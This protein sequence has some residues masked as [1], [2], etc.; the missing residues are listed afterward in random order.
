MLQVTFNLCIL[1][2]FLLGSVSLPVSAQ[3]YHWQLKQNTQDSS[4]PVLQ[5]TDYTIYLPQISQS[6]T[7]DDQVFEVRPGALRTKSFDGGVVTLVAAAGSASA[8]VIFQYTPE[9]SPLPEALKTFSI[10]ASTTWDFPLAAQVRYSNTVVEARLGIF[11]Y[12]TE[13]A[14]WVEIPSQV[15][16]DTVV[17]LI[18]Q[19]GRYALVQDAP[20]DE[21]YVCL[22]S[23]AEMTASAAQTA[24]RAIR[25]QIDPAGSALVQV[26]ITGDVERAQI[27]GG[28]PGQLAVPLAHTPAYGVDVWTAIFTGIPNNRVIH[29]T[30]TAEG[31]DGSNAT[32]EGALRGWN[33]HDPGVD[34]IHN[35][36]DGWVPVAGETAPGTRQR[37][38][39]PHSDVLTA[40]G[41][42]FH[43]MPLLSLPG[44]GDSDIKLTLTY[45]AQGQADGPVG[46]GWFFSYGMN[47][48]FVDTPLLRGAEIR[49]PDG[50]L[51]RFANVGGSIFEPVDPGIN[52]RLEST[53]AGYRLTRAKTL[54]SY[55]F[56]AEGRLTGVQD[57][58]QNPVR[59][60]YE[61]GRLVR[62]ENNGLRSSTLA[63]NEAGQ[64]VSITASSRQVLLAYE[65][66]RL[67]S[68]TDAS[69][70]VWQFAY[71]TRET[72][73]VLGADGQEITLVDQL[74]T[75]WTDPNGAVQGRQEYDELGRV[76]EQTTAASGQRTFAYD[77]VNRE[78]VVTDAYD[79]T[80]RYRFDE[81]WRLVEQIAPDGSRETFGYDEDFNRTRYE[82]AAG[83]V[84]QWGYD[85]AG[86]LLREEGPLGWLRS[87][88]YNTLG[89]PVRAAENLD[90]STTRES[91]FTYDAAGNLR[92]ITN[93]LG[94]VADYRYDER[95][96]LTRAQD[97]AGR[98]IYY[99]YNNRGDLTSRSNGIESTLFRRDDAGRLE[100]LTLPEGQVYTYAYDSLDRLTAVGGPLSFS[101]TY[102]YDPS[103]NLI[104]ETAP[105]GAV[106][107]YEVDS[108]G[109]LTAEID[110]LGSR[111]TY[112]YGAMGE[113]ARVIDAEGRE[114]EF[115]YDV[116]QRMV[117]VSEP[118]G[119]VTRYTYDA[120]GNRVS[121]TDAEGRVLHTEF[122]AL[123]RP[124][125]VTEN[126]R[127]G[128]P[129]SAD[130][131]L[132]TT[133]IYDLG[134]RALQTTDPEGNPT[135]YTYDLLDRLTVLTNAEGGLWSF[136]YDPAGSLTS[137]T[138]PRGAVTGYD[139]DISNRLIR[140]TD[141]Y[142]NVTRYEYN[143][144]GWQTAV[145]DPLGVVT[146]YDYDDLGRAVAETRS[147]VPG[148]APSAQVNVTTTYEF[149]L[150]GKLL[151]A[152]DPR[153]SRAAY[154]YD[155]AGRLL[156]AS[157]FA[158]AV[159]RYTYDRIG[160]LRSI[161]DPN[162]GVTRYTMDA[163]NR[164]AVITNPEDHTIR[165]AYNLRDELV[166]ITDANGSTTTFSLDGVGRVRKQTDALGGV[167]QF[168]YNRTGRITTETA[169]NGSSRRYTYDRIYRPLTYT[170]G[171]GGVT[172]YAWD[173]GSNLVSLIDPLERATTYEYDLLN[174]LTAFTLPSGAVERYT[175]DASGSQTAKI[176]A[177]G[178]ATS[179]TY[180]PLYRLTTVTQNFVA[181]APS[182][183]D[184][185]VITQYAY[186]AS[187][188]LV[189]IT[190]PLGA[191]TRFERDAMGRP[192]R[193][194]DPLGNA[195]AYTWDAAGNLTARQD[196][197]GA[198]T[199][200]SYYPDHMLRRVEYPG[201][202]Q[203]TFAYDPNN[204]RTAMNGSFGKSRWEYDPL[205]R[206]TRAED[207]LGRR[208]KLGY[209]AAGNRTSLTYPNDYQ[210]RWQYDAENRMSAMIDPAGRETIY[211]R[212]AAGSI[213][214]ITYPNDIT[215]QIAYTQDTQIESLIYRQNEN[216]ITRFA[217]AYSPAGD[218]TRITSQHEGSQSASV[219]EQYAY[220]PLHR[221]AGVESSAGGA[222]SYQY[223]AASNRI[224]WTGADNPLTP[225]PGDSFQAA[226]T[227]NPANLLTQAQITG[228]IDSTIS[229]TYDANG[230]RVDQRVEGGPGPALGMRYVYD[231]ENRLVSTQAY[232]V[233]DRG[234]TAESGITSFSYDGLGR[235]MVQQYKPRSGSSWQRN[236]LLYDGLDPIAEYQPRSCRWS[237]FYRGAENA[238]VALQRFPATSTKDLNEAEG[239]NEEELARS[240]GVDEAALPPLMGDELPMGAE[241]LPPDT[242]V[243]Q[244]EIG[245]PTGGS[246]HSARGNTYWYL[247]NARGDVT[248]LTGQ[249]GQF[250]HDYTYD[251]Y[252][253]LTPDEGTFTTPLNRFTFSGKR[254]DENTGLVYFGARHYDPL[255]GVWLTQD[256]WRGDISDPVSL[257]RTL[258]ANA[259]PLT[260][261]EAYGFQPEPVNPGGADQLESLLADP[262]ARQ[263]SDS[264][265]F[266]QH[267]F[268][269]AAGGSY[270][271]PE[272]RM[273][274]TSLYFDLNP[275][276]EEYGL[277]VSAA[278]RLFG[279]YSG[280]GIQP[281]ADGKLAQQISTQQTVYR[282][283]FVAPGITGYV[284]QD[285]P[286]LRLPAQVEVGHSGL[287]MAFDSFNPYASKA[288][289]AGMASTEKQLRAAA[290][291]DAFDG[292]FISC[293]TNAVGISWGCAFSERGAAYTGLHTAIPSHTNTGAACTVE[294]GLGRCLSGTLNGRSLNPEVFT[295]IYDESDTCL[296]RQPQPRNPLFVR[297]PE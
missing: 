42:L 199:E 270:A 48:R 96:L 277:G 138:S 173:A 295:A 273:E 34:C 255:A 68:V 94:A 252:G 7:V 281:V 166:A 235:L 29:F 119:A 230:N 241:G 209:D 9:T 168:E 217:Y 108:A 242:Q 86:N 174:R 1:L 181:G 261:R 196:A 33:N 65:D 190:N 120:A 24:I 205:N 125:A 170:A 180:D 289:A 133:Y 54:I 137:A 257:H 52:D 79:N 274:G 90:D 183:A 5:E 107:S 292:A 25:T 51:I 62:I 142:G 85:S 286:A 188:G 285:T 279:R 98:I 201:D 178:I 136:A 44:P 254:L 176:D 17:A 75:V 233:V 11:Q 296:V 58:N 182:T 164:R 35:A 27:T 160:N 198:L 187:G 132:T 69:G 53:A 193:E 195:W 143:Q 202:K 243:P 123:N 214:G 245:E 10:T 185:N 91:L 135:R 70:G 59:L 246:G 234:R 189:E 66:D 50:R 219:T 57:R 117:E 80:T 30:V 179:Y 225:Q 144:N 49:Y 46:R 172:R 284:D 130:T 124:V 212:D 266:I 61:G 84:W 40:H 161:T 276:Q 267:H 81:L 140:E 8:P 121:V 204:N 297:L 155:V 153:G 26:Q 253:I 151:A 271:V 240:C 134:G 278:G 45:H 131:N 232:Q 83:R 237:Y 67:V 165:Y 215:A 122:D 263:F 184:Q 149:D 71:E 126:Y 150:A 128:A 248:G 175:Y 109:R 251:P 291:A 200:Y 115:G 288:Q 89:L 111:T 39:V 64:I 127:P 103:G 268:F 139:Y 15:D 203:V 31:T 226:F 76:V 158:G 171:D 82:D 146:A 167:W 147:A 74:L 159:T 4:L 14:A 23:A 186:D 223:D 228:S 6:N 101:L 105:T 113:L 192:M 13:N 145:I 55:L 197:N 63:Y 102:Q 220:D 156:S 256:L 157:D 272:Y 104:A 287:L 207:A 163:R 229:Y 247:H 99:T 93:P 141:A 194:I 28:S 18:E 224:L 116:L 211:T 110:P 293:S 191:V 41:S 97:F 280:Y 239:L 56:D 210:V 250:V 260:M 112:V 60:I 208:I 19:Q 218:V 114:T 38:L 283:G 78:T 36:C 221:L 169:P 236:E 206:V 100:Q 32:L 269:N 20:C 262:L 77:E 216:E 258:F 72:P 177:D 2:T 16:A 73:G 22:A 3:S 148:E 231:T 88:E 162:G 92:T 264:G 259:N 294:N 282:L 47:M 227:Y 275:N 43:R 238:L 290:E 213:T 265:V 106:T 249:N 87:W 154:S 152:T 129:A 21:L 118:L 222:S 244:L 95:G 37:E 12:Q